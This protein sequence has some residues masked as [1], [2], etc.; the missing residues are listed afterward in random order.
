MED[1][2]LGEPAQV[3]EE[4]QIIGYMLKHVEGEGEI[5]GA[6]SRRLIER[7]AVDEAEALVGAGGGE[8]V[9]GLSDLI[10]GEVTSG[11]EPGLQAGQHAAAAASNVGDPL[12]LDAGRPDHVTDMGCLPRGVL[13]VPISRVLKIGAVPIPFLEIHRRPPN[14]FGP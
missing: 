2:S 7:A 14:E 11:R 9:G 6:C 13:F 4:T 10:A 12:G 1:E 8:A 3:G 5:I